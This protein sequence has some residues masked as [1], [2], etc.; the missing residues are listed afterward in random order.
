M[1]KKRKNFI[2]PA[3]CAVLGIALC[4]SL[5][6]AE[7]VFSV[8]GVNGYTWL[9]AETDFE[10]LPENQPLPVGKNGIGIFDYGDETSAG[11]HAARAV[12]GPTDAI[13]SQNHH[14][15]AEL[16]AISDGE[17]ENVLG[18]RYAVIDPDY[19]PSQNPSEDLRRKFLEVKL[20]E[21]ILWSS[22][23]VSGDVGFAD[24]DCE[25]VQGH[26]RRPFVSLVHFAN[27]RIT[28]PNAPG[29]S[30]SFAANRW[31]HLT[32][33]LDFIGG[34]YT[35]YLG[36]SCIGESVPFYS[37]GQ[38]GIMA[39]SL[40][41]RL[42]PQNISGS[43]ERLYIDNIR[44]HAA[45][46]TARAFVTE[47]IVAEN[48]FS[49]GMPTSNN[50]TLGSFAAKGKA[51]WKGARVD[52]ETHGGVIRLFR[53][54]A[55][56][57]V[58][59]GFFRANYCNMV[60]TED[61]GGNQTVTDPKKLAELKHVFFSV[62]LMFSDWVNGNLNYVDKKADN[63]RSVVSLAHFD[64]QGYVKF[65]TDSKNGEKAAANVI[66]YEPMK[67]YNFRLYMDFETQT[68]TLCVNGR[69]I[70]ERQPLPTGATPSLYCF[71][72]YFQFGSRHTGC[73]DDYV[74]IDNYV[75]RLA[76]CTYTPRLNRLWQAPDICKLACFPARTVDMVLARYDSGG[77]LLKGLRI[78]RGDDTTY[79]LMEI[80]GEETKTAERVFWWQLDQLVP[81]S[82]MPLP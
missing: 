2:K 18:L 58:T 61:P 14:M 56:G 1:R 28:L 72:V 65:Y 12:C 30:V 76:S 7:E 17:S 21:D 23:A 69:N 29:K 60:G 8:N 79:H 82:G 19:D 54:D 6:S 44:Y 39:L 53:T 45:P 36:E 50:V 31:Y 33:Y 13:G 51:I 67:W 70:I 49:E 71:T 24:Y 48:D 10:G 47:R 74:E 38:T 77:T 75:L 81:L 43:A 68:Y 25:N 22:A 40:M 34:T 35:A 66:A 63:S 26:G 62:D 3:A 15:V 42:N 59:D 57:E 41:T 9:I 37:D 32:F 64:P 52:P 11:Q 78:S 55:A 27:G 16:P 20:E 4:G 5:A 46:M 80:R 73:E